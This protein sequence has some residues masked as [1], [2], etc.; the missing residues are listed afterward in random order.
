MKDVEI[1]ALIR[2][3]AKDCMRLCDNRE[4]HKQLQET[5][6]RIK[7]LATQLSRLYDPPKPV[8]VKQ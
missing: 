6:D 5:A 8:E 1:I 3:H 2:H 4:N 7:A